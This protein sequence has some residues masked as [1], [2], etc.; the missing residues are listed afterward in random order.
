[1]TPATAAKLES[2]GIA[3]RKPLP[4]PIILGAFD[5]KEAGRATHYIRVTLVLDGRA[6][7]KQNFLI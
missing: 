6:I 2:A 4:H 1:M 7:P 3:F 5:G